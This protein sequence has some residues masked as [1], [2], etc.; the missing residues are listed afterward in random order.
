MAE[1][2]A[3]VDVLNRDPSAGPQALL[4]VL[5]CSRGIAQMR[6][7]E[8]RIC[9]VEGQLRVQFSDSGIHELHVAEWS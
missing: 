6:E 5:K 1:V 2:A 7:Q 9:Q 8:A 3:E 4:D